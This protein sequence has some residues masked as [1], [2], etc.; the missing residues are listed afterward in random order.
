MIPGIIMGIRGVILT[1]I[2]IPITA[3]MVTTDITLLTIMADLILTRTIAATRM[4]YIPQIPPTGL[5]IQVI[6]AQAALHAVIIQIGVR[7][8]QGLHRLPSPVEA[9]VAA[10]RQ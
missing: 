9:A 10:V 8:V 6:A 7:A 5:A 2:L 1:G 4:S 3:G